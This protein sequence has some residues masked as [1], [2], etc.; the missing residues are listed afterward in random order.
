M[1]ALPAQLCRTF[2]LRIPVHDSK[3]ARQLAFA[4][5]EKRG[6]PVP[7]SEQSGFACHTVPLPDGS[8]ILSVDVPAASVPGALAGPR[9]PAGLLASARC[10]P[11]DGSTLILTMELG[12]R[13][14]WAVC[15]GTVVHTQILTAA[16]DQPAGL[17]AELRLA[18]LCLQ[19]QE[20]T[21]SPAVLEVWD[22]AGFDTLET[23]AITLNLQIRHAERPAPDP[24][25]IDRLAGARLLPAAGGAP[26]RRHQL[27]L[28]KGAAAA[29]LAGSGL[30]WG[31]VQY[32]QLAALET[33]AASLAASLNASSGDDARQ[34]ALRQEVRS[35]QENW[36]G[37]RMALDPDRY[38][39]IHLNRLTRCLGDGGIVLSRFES[40]GPE[41]SV[42]GTAQTA[43]GAYQFYSTVTADPDLRIYGWSMVQPLIA[44]NGTASFQIKGK[45]R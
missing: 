34:Q 33:K 8:A 2:A 31:L 36:Q 1:V 39:M 25:R 9:P 32:R 15:Q 20:L 42:N 29:V 44:D 16:R 41:L 24:A 30:V 23:L 14:L 45:M 10:F 3:T 6:L 21:P 38:P 26:Q 22:D 28:L 7:P 11:V 35:A 4:Q 43:L 37:L 18:C 17:L 27:R 40:K 5:L 13:V 19:Q 12:R